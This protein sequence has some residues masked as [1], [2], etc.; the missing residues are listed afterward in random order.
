MRNK[1]GHYEVLIKDPIIAEHIPET[2]W[3]NNKALANMLE[4]YPS[5]YLKPNDNTGGNGIIRIKRIKKIKYL[6]SVDKKTKEIDQRMLNNVLKEVINHPEKY[7][8]QQG[9]ELS[10]Y[11]Y[12][13]FDMRIVL[14]KALNTWRLTLTSVKVAATRNAVVTNVSK[15][16]TD[17]PLHKI[18]QRYDQKKEPMIIF[19][20]MIDLSHQIANVLGNSKPLKIV[21]LDIALDKSGK[22]WFIEAN[23]HPECGR[24]KLVNDQLSVKKYEKTSKLSKNEA[25]GKKG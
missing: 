19:R 25:I 17:Y 21:G 24:C 9:I 1:M 5:I 10:T 16:A 4:K 3:Y 13:P 20:E 15:G 6:V 2:C 14:Q 7:I 18:L 23:E 12:K 11:N 8:I 22:L